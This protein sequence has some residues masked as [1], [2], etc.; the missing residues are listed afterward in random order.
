MATTKKT[1]ILGRMKDA[2]TGM[3]SSQPARKSPERVEAGKKAATTAKV[4]KAVTA[5]KTA[6]K[7][8]AKAVS[9]ATKKGAGRKRR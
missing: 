8:A 2:V 9:P 5:T 6:A 7:K 4:T 3:F 1:G